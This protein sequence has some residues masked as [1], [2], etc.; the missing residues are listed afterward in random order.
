VLLGSKEDAMLEVSLIIPAYNEEGRLPGTLAVYGRGMREQFG[1][2]FEIVVVANG[3][4]DGTVAVAKEAAMEDPWVRVVEVE[5]AVGK[6]GAVLEG[7][8][9][10]RG[11]AVAFADADGATSPESL[12]MLL[13]ALER[14]DIV[15]GSR[16]LKSSTITLP[17]T[18]SRRLL[19]F[20]FARTARF[21]FGMPFKDTQCGAKALRAEAARRLCGV[22]SETRW[23]FDLDLLL[24]ARRLGLTI[25]EHPVT[26][27]DKRGSRLRYASTTWE[28]LQALWTM[29]HRQQLPLEVLPEPPVFGEEGERTPEADERTPVVS[30]V[31]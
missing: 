5:E 26:W 4:A 12:I 31:A 9:R 3:C 20:V 22:V 27:A 19:G 15:I 14:S 17:Q 16:R 1:E 30:E 6:G 25:S 24:C 28:V 13:R 2:N 21:L 29:K 10:A 8:R 11:A 18:P 23:T 7:F